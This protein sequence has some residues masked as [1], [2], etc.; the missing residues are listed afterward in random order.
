LPEP[1]AGDYVDWWLSG[2]SLEV[3]IVLA[4]PP[5]GREHKPTRQS[6]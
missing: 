3:S 4:V 2:A 5:G 6:L 1:V